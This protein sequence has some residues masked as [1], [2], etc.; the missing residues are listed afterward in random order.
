M[1]NSLSLALLAVSSFWG[2]SALNPRVFVGGLVWLTIRHVLIPLMV[3]FFWQN[4]NWQKRRFKVGVR[5][6]WYSLR[7]FSVRIKLSSSWS[8]PAA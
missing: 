8:E 2:G 1:V 5:L 3:F 6:P 7:R 4:K